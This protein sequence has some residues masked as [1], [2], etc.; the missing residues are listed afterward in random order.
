MMTTAA[1]MIVV[2][3]VSLGGCAL[4][5]GV[6]DDVPRQISVTLWTRSF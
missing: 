6:R 1:I 2:A 4:Y 5:R 3:A